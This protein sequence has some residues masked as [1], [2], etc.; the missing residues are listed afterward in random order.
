MF[1]LFDPI[2]ALGHIGE[3]VAE[4][5]ER[6]FIEL[7]L[8]WDDLVESI[9]IRVVPRHVVSPNRAYAESGNACPNK[10]LLSKT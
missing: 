9:G 5:G 4:Y 3:N 7:E 1:G 2:D 10:R 8:A 6:G